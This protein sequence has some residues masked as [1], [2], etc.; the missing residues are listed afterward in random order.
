MND[1]DKSEFAALMT[2]L[3]ENF[4]AQLSKPGLA[5]RFEALR[6]HSIEAVRAACMSLLNTRKYRQ[7]PTVAEFLE[8]LGGGSVDDIA[9]V[10]AAKVVR[11]VKELGGYRSV[12]FDNATTQAVIE[13]SFG[14]WVKL[15]EELTGEN[16]KWVAK[17]FVKAYGAYS[18]QG[19]TLAGHL[20]GRSEI[21]NGS[22]LY[23]RKVEVA[24]V[25]DMQKALAIAQAGE[26]ERR[27]LDAS[28]T[29]GNVL[30]LVDRLKRTS[31]A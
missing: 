31:A 5:L 28:P 3:A 24:L 12:A 23:E 26:G 19:V 10:E 7:M 4:G 15:C 8:H 1:L 2:G 9:A 21:V 11:A 13:H 29:A 17:D 16:E 20:S 22:G 6:E 14:G 18:R 25:G 27:G 30:R